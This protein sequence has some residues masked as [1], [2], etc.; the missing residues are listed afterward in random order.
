MEAKLR[1]PSWLQSS[2]AIIYRLSSVFSFNLKT[3]GATCTNTDWEWMPRVS[4]RLQRLE[5]RSSRMGTSHQAGAPFTGETTSR[6][7]KRIKLAPSTENS[8]TLLDLH[9]LKRLQPSGAL[10]ESNQTVLSKESLVIAG[11]S[12]LPPQSLSRK[13]ESKRSSPRKSTA[14]MVS[15]CSTCSTWGNQ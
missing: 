14:Q 1:I 7:G 2:R 13:R 11:S 4:P 8:S 15:S 6:P 12:Q 5:P 3:S 9:K 10:T